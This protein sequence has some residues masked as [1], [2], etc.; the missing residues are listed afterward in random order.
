MGTDNKGIRRLRLLPTAYL[1]AG[2]LV[3]V[4]LVSNDTG[5]SV[6]QTDITINGTTTEN[7]KYTHYL[8]SIYTITS[9]EN[10]A[11]NLV[12]YPGQ[13]TSKDGNAENLF[14]QWSTYPSTGTDLEDIYGQ[15]LIGDSD[16][17][18]KTKVEIYKLGIKYSTEDTGDT[19]VDDSTIAIPEID[20]DSA[21][22]L[23]GATLDSNEWNGI[24]TF[25]FEDK[26]WYEIRYYWKL[27][28][29]RYLYDSKIVVID[30]DEYEINAINNLLNSKK[31]YEEGKVEI[32]NDF[33]QDS[34]LT[35]DLTLE[36]ATEADRDVNVTVNDNT[37]VKSKKISNFHTDKAIVG[38]N[39]DENHIMGRVTVRISNDGNN[40]IE[41]PVEL[42]DGYETIYSYLYQ[43]TE[44][45]KN[46]ELK[47]YYTTKVGDP[48]KVE[49]K[50]ST[51]VENDNTYL[52]FEYL[53]DGATA[54]H[55]SNIEVVA[56]Y[57]TLEDITV[58]KIWDD[59]NNE[60]RPESIKLTLTDGTNLYEKEVTEADGWKF[61]VEDLPTSDVDNNLISYTVDEEEINANDLMYYSKQINNYE[62]TNT[63]KVH[64]ITTLV[65]GE[66]GT[67]SGQDETPY[68]KVEHTASSTKDIVVKADEGY[69]IKNITLTYEDGTTENVEITG[70]VTEKTLDKFTNMTQ[71]VTVTAEFEKIPAKVI[72]K[73]VDA[74]TSE[75]I[76]E[77]TMD[78]F[79]NETYTAEEKV[80]DGY[81][82][83]ETPDNASGVYT[84]E[85]IEVIYYYKKVSAGVE[86][87]YV[88]QA[89]GTEIETPVTMNGLE[90]D[91]Y[92][93]EA[94]EV[95]GYVL[96]TTPDNATGEMTV[97]KITVT[98]EYRKLV[99]VEV[100][101]V[102]E[103]SNEEII[104]PEIQNLKEGDTYTT[105]KKDF[106]GYT[107]TK[108]TGNTT[109]T[110]GNADVEVVYYYKK[111][112]D[113]VE[114]KY[115][116][117]VTGEELVPSETIEGLEKDE[118]ETE[119]KD[120][121]GYELVVTPDNATG[122]M[123]EEKTTVIYEY[124]KI[125]NV[126]AKY[127][128]ENT[129]EEIVESI[130]QTLKEGDEYTTEKKSF[131]NYVYTKD[132][133]NVAG[134][135]GNTDVEVI[136]Y[137]KKV[138]DGVEIKYIDQVTGEEIAPSE[139]I[140]GLEKDEYET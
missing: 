100:R 136:Y 29:G 132:T 109:G 82:L 129:N 46:E 68:E 107:Y 118:Y 128:D 47:E 65:A 139:T 11:D 131:D 32:T 87:K 55:N 64:E 84:E 51:L 102:D 113:G 13:V 18:G 8:D 80:L 12:K 135:L 69:R 4:N 77:V 58:T 48:V 101:Y 97:D 125:V 73:Y 24:D 5:T 6:L 49:V 138:S 44:I 57:I 15:A 122:E 22:K 50:L 98:Y 3:N 78:G 126:V 60:K 79:L 45:N 93:T 119:P 83:V 110:I 114:I 66:G 21:V 43:E 70:T 61:T 19:S 1:Y 62:I 85:D 20:Y 40:W 9:A 133:G 116:D 10:L 59:E 92:T 33:V 86:V 121:P 111:I 52:M 71:G 134:T 27:N 53:D 38:I 94:K 124:R 72:V 67:I 123:T 41:V 14:A 31:Y 35:T 99:N 74:N 112:S 96:V 103:N 63:L 137:Y 26:G 120:I 127:L 7:T 37:V 115:I 130:T 117:Q 140:E 34:I 90:K 104:T 88:D 30:S 25:D 76:E 39:N 2:E 28:D 95:S 81:K 91:P 75:V 36:A 17:N 105:E 56:D 23:E 54:A 42:T 16:P 106:D 108:D 89:T